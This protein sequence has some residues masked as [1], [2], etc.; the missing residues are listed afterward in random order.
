MV[1]NINKG[2]TLALTGA[3]ILRL[4]LVTRNKVPVEADK[5]TANVYPN[6]ASGNANFEFTSPSAGEV[7]ISVFDLSGK[8]SA[9]ETFFLE[10][11][12]HEFSISGLQEGF[13]LIH[14]KGPNFHF[15]L[16]LICT[17]RNGGRF[18]IRKAE[19]SVTLLDKNNIKVAR[20]VAGNYVDM[21]YS[22]GEKLIFTGKNGAYTTIV[23]Y[24]PVSDKTIILIS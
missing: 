24:I 9:I 10:M 16:R 22:V 6:P 18:I 2:T 7:V 8:Q 17:E 12:R 20:G 15:A 5:Q 19:G 3:D 23:S 11:G 13:C 14:V 1:E 4:N 21:D